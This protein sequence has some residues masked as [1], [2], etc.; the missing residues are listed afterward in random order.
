M[1]TPSFRTPV[2]FTALCVGLTG[3]TSTGK[4]QDKE[5]IGLQVGGV[6]GGVAGAVAAKKLGMGSQGKQWGIVGGALAGAVVGSALGKKLDDS[7]REE[8]AR[9]AQT[10]LDSGKKVSWSS[11]Q[12]G[13][14]G[15][16]ETFPANDGSRTS[17]CKVV[18]QTV[19]SQKKTESEDLKMCKTNSG[20]EVRS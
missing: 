14:K 5:Q 17:E 18:R 9:A 11:P 13:N 1:K 6:V 19:T 2:I 12:S 8:M 16:A 7:D 10:A 20:W 4:S 3:C 15:S